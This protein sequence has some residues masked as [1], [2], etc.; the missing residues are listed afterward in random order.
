[1]STSVSGDGRSHPDYVEKLGFVGTVARMRATSAVVVLAIA[2][3]GCSPDS[4]DPLADESTTEAPPEATT[5]TTTTVT[6]P[7]EEEAET[8][9]VVGVLD[10]DSLRVSKDGSTEDVRLLGINAPEADECYGD[11]ARTT[12]TNLLAGSEVVMEAGEEETDGNGRLL[13]YLYLETEEGTVFVNAELMR[14]GAAVG[15]QNGHIHQD[16][17]KAFEDRAFSSGLGMW[18]TFACGQPEGGSPDRPQLRVTEMSTDPEGDDGAVLEEEWIE[19][20]NESYTT[21]DI[22]GWT[23]RDESTSNRY[24]IPVGVGLNPGDTLRLVTGCGTSGAMT[25]FWCSETAVWSNGGD[26]VLLLDGQGNVI[27]RHVYGG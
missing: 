19:L 8:A 26:T 22:G 15:L 9:L 18:A 10:G 23:V 4:A 16:D 24:T 12:L 27:E 7:P 6:L 11:S 14:A 1:M 21:I 3:A 17:F 25:L 13:R 2:L 5:T 20:T